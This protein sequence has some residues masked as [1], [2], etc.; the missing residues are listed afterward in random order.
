VAMKT[1]RTILLASVVSLALGIAPAGASAPERVTFTIPEF[2][3]FDAGEQCAFPILLHFIDNEGTATLFYDDEGNL[4]RE[5]DSGHLSVVVSNEETGAS[6]F[7]N[8]SGPQMITYLSDGG[9]RIEFRGPGLFSLFPGDV[10]GPGLIR[11]LGNVIFTRDASGAITS[12]SPSGQVI[13]VCTVLS[14]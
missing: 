5:I 7:Y 13:D 3:D 1:A 8:I 6:V 10:N 11:T 2:I 14:S 9:Q 4:V 12:I